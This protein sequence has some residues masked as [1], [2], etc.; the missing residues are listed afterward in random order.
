MKPLIS[1]VIPTRERPSL[2]VRAVQSVLTQT[3]DTIEIIVVI[4]GPDAATSQVL[5]QIDDPRLKVRTLPERLG[6]SAARNAG[7][8]EAKSHWIA[9]LDDDDEWFPR[10]LEI[11]L[12]AAE[13]SFYLYPII[14]CRLIARSEAGDLV[15][16]RRYPSPGKHLSEYLFCQ[17]GL[18][19]GEGLILPSALLTKRELLWKVPFKRGMLRHNDVDWLLR[20]STLEGFG[21]E[22]V[23]SPAPLVIWHIEDNRRRISNT[24]DWRF[25]LSWIQTNRHLV[26]PRAYASFLMTWA[27]L[28]AARGRD[29]KAFWLLPREASRHGKPKIIDLLAHLVI[30]LIP[31][32][33]RR[34]VAVFFERRRLGEAG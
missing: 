20:A 9:F 10:K 3:L 11:Q 30:W 29:W 18:L 25:S 27:S 21:I 17:S 2:A 14:S 16:P 1:V 12:Q 33:V 13:K 6:A 32:A 8:S 4:D 24:T 7:V 22:F 23:S 28:T 34:R 19:G 5:F 31:P 26:T 15:W